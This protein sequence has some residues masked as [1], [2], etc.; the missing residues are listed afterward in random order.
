VLVAKTRT[1]LETT[2]AREFCLGGGV[3]AHPALRD[4]L[5]RRIE[6]MGVRVT[7]PPLSACTDNA[8]MIAVAALRH[9]EMGRFADLHIDI[10]AHAP[11][12]DEHTVNR[13]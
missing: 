12:D 4:E 6:E 7:L 3:A 8:G 9:Y 1:A 13:V 10:K 2:G 5:K 11:L